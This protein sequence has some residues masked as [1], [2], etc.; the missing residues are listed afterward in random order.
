MSPKANYGLSIDLKFSIVYDGMVMEQQKNHM[1][2][3]VK[4]FISI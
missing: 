3:C 1:Q 4:T 2:S